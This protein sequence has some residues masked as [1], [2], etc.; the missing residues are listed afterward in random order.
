M[1]NCFRKMSIAL[2]LALTMLFSIGCDTEITP[3]DTEPYVSESISIV[4]ASKLTLHV[5]ETFKLLTNLSEDRLNDVEWTSSNC[6]VTVTDLGFVIAREIGKVTVTARIGNSSDKVLI[7]VIDAEN[8]SESFEITENITTSGFETSELTE[9]TTASSSETFELTESITTSS[10]DNSEF[11]ENITASNSE[12]GTVE[13]SL[14]TETENKEK[15]ETETTTNVETEQANPDVDIASKDE[16]YGN[17]IPAAS[18]DEA[19]SRSERGE[20][21]GAL[22]VPNQAPVI[23]DYRPQI[24]GLFV[25]NSVSYFIDQNTYVV[26]NAYGQEVFRVYRGGGYITLEEVAA[27][28]YAFGD[29]PANYSANKKAS[30]SSSIWREYLRVNHSYFSG[31]VSKYPYEPELPNISGCGGELKYYELDIGTT[32]TDCDPEYKSALYNNGSS[33]TRGA[34]RIVYARFDKNGNNIIDPNERYVFYTYNHYNDFQ[35]YLNYYGG[36]GEMFG[37][38]TGGG[39]ISSKT[40]CNP[41]NYVQTVKAALTDSRDATVKSNSYIFIA[42]IL[43]RDLYYTRKM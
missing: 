42:V 19:L 20:L 7:E 37:N 21:S 1:K 34:A 38:I 29:V 41:T 24:N 27:Y 15:T 39:T 35:E 31:S 33:I 12:T 32:G 23:S 8:S 9:N 11:T 40:D 3:K 16:F 30:P 36:W 26:V 5:G 13:S 43:P 10:S 28:V 14:E 18:Y 22:T 4:N 17:S 6:N 2:L 25:R